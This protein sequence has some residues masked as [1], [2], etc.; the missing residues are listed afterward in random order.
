QP[1]PAGPPTAKIITNSF[2]MKLAF[3]PAGKF[4]MGSPPTEAERDEHEVQHE[5]TISKP[6]Y[7]GVFE[8]TQREYKSLMGANAGKA[9]FH[10]QRGGSPDHPMENIKWDQAVAFCRALSNLPTEQQA[11]RNYRLPTEAEWEYACR[12]GTTTAFHCGNSLSSKLAN[13]NGSF[14]FGGA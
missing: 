7:M 5:V 3:I 6:F 10:D 1:A 11:G 4:L 8:V 13:F 14:P 12:A 9:I 2:G